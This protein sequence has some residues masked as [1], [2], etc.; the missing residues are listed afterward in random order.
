MSAGTTSARRGYEIFL[1]RDGVIEL[2]D[3]N[4]RL[5]ADRLRPISKRMMSHYRSLLRYDQPRYVP[6]NAFDQWRKQNPRS[7]SSVAI[8]AP[9]GFDLR[10]LADRLLALGLEV[11]LAGQG[12]NTGSSISESVVDE[13]EDTD[14]FIGIIAGGDVS[15]SLF[16]LGLAVGLK[17]PVLIAVERSRGEVP[18]PL[19]WLPRVDFD[20]GHLEPLV[21]AVRRMRVPSPAPRTTSRRKKPVIEHRPPR[22]VAHVSAAFDFETAVAELVTAA[23]VEAYRSDGSAD[24]GFD[25]A[26]W[27]PALE[28]LIPNPLLVE[29]KLSL[30]SNP[31]QAI[32]QVHR[33][34]HRTG[35]EGVA[36]LIYGEG[37]PSSELLTQTPTVLP[38]RFDEL[39][40]ELRVSDF[41]VVVQRR[42]NEIAHGISR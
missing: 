25:L 12:A 41:H 13:M 35:A 27:D 20:V 42:R 5:A 32:A 15:D 38:I 40:A 36:L 22:A 1:Q 2:E 23:G 6:I 34:R 16:E 31:E 39:E 29:I 9:R 11:Q 37:P 21:D 28:P 8:S 19:Y 3:V 26:I 18:G 10:S 17:K 14:A 7:I 24:E 4:A 33:L 30:Q